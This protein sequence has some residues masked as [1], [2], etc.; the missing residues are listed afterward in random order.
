M[1]RESAYL[2]NAFAVAKFK[3]YGSFVY[4]NFLLF[5]PLVEA[6]EFYNNDN[7]ENGFALV[8]HVYQ[9]FFTDRLVSCDMSC[10]T[11][12]TCKQLKLQSC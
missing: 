5:R 7:P 4:H 12:P 10:S 6:G 11:Q 3:E 1:K 9:S 8:D 2:E